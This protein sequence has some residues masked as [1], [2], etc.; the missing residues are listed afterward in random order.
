MNKAIENLIK[1][2]DVLRMKYTEGNGQWQQYYNEFENDIIN[3]EN[4]LS[5]YD[6]KNRNSEESLAERL[7]EIGREKQTA[8]DYVEGPLFN[9]SLIETA[10]E[11][12]Y[13]RLIIVFHHL[14]IDGVSWG[15]LLSDLMILLNEGSLP[16]KSTSYQ[17]WSASLQKLAIDQNW[18]S[19]S[20]YWSNV[21]AETNRTEYL[22]DHSIIERDTITF[23]IEKEMA[24]SLIG[25][26][27]SVYNTSANELLL[28]ALNAAF[29]EWSSI[30]SFSVQLE[31]HGR[32]DLFD[33][34]D[35]SRTVGWFTSLFPVVF[36][37]QKNIQDNIQYV[38]KS[39]KAIPYK[40]IGYGVLK[41]LSDIEWDKKEQPANVTFNYFGDV[42]QIANESQLLQL[43]TDSIGESI[44]P[45]Y[46]SPGIL[47]TGASN[48]NG[49]EFKLDKSYKLKNNLS[50]ELLGKEFE[51]QLT[52]MY[53]HCILKI[54]TGEGNVINQFVDDYYSG[55]IKN[56]NSLSSAFNTDLYEG[57]M[58]E[59]NNSE[60][61]N[62][63]Y[64][65]PPGGGTSLLYYRLV[66][67]LGTEFRCFGFQMKGLEEDVELDKTMVGIAKRFC[68]E[69]LT[70]HGKDSNEI[71]LIGY[72]LGVLVSYEMTRIL[73]NM[74]YNVQ[75]VLLDEGIPKPIGTHTPS[76]EAA[77][78]EDIK[79]IKEYDVVNLLDDVQLE[80]IKKVFRNNNYMYCNYF[81]NHQISADILGVDAN[82]NKVPTN[83]SDWGMLTNG[84]LQMFGINAHHGNL[85][86]S[87]SAIDE[88]VD[89]C[90]T[91]LHRKPMQ[92][93]E[94]EV[95]NY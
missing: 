73:E 84:E 41:H 46:L 22:L 67:K 1:Y 86:E 2:H 91:W 27:N 57:S 89:K 36:K 44:D 10:N 4:N 72:S 26:C 8:L 80:R 29:S 31:G 33:D 54:N 61:T 34:I 88:I 95:S 90:L 9:F 18:L 50:L 74:G 12:E 63:L 69:L 71:T 25:A 75:L 32:E 68:D 17:Y 47:I 14:I 16:P 38:K 66:P 87:F 24:Q 35:I 6:L 53:N 7:A 19:Q 45:N 62:H 82:E 15:I 5:I 65:I 49:L 92:T 59:L 78:I 56:S 21:Q 94:I 11:F 52:A 28:A 55:D 51:K 70:V 85:L 76:N 81:S 42:S 60:S 58:F 77:L 43:S 37:G 93:G 64:F 40:G 23:T 48:E 79:K 20:N 30:N 3:Y 83:M 39:L 13:N